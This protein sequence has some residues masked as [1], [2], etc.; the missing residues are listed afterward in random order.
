MKALTYAGPQAISFGELEDPVLPGPDGAIVRVT[1][2]GICGSDLHIYAGHGFTPGTGYGVGHEAVGEIVELGPQANGLSVGDR[3]LVAASAG[4]D[5]CGNCR[6]GVVAACERQPLPVDACYG[7]GGSLPGAQA[8]LL[9]VPH[10]G[11]NLV[12]LPDAIGDEAAIVLTD[13]AP[14]AWYGARRARIAPGDTV[15]VIGLGPVGLM[16]VQ[17]AF[18]MGAARVLGVDLVADRRA[19][20]AEL[21]AE[22][23]ESDDPKTAVRE[24]LGGGADVALEAVG[25][26]ATIKLATSVVGHRGRVSVVGVS[27]NRAYP[28]HM[29][30]AQVKELEFHIGLCSVQ[31]ELPALL[32]LT[33]AGRL[34]PEAVVSHR[35]PMSEGPDAYRMFAARDDKV[36]KVV[37]DPWQ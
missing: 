15:V 22:P 12:R 14:T 5:R 30:L 10:A 6:A 17:S 27:Q 7:L 35:M 21:G 33:A 4:C 19:R 28:F 26:D 3:V 9:A 8:Q 37:L 25:A 32:K 20:A 29:P 2:A 24:M 16:A 31:Y 23:V 13:N 36:C 34:R 1:A 11:G 18:A